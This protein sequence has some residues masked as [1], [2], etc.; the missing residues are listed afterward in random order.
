MAKMPKAPKAS[1]TLK[2]LQAYE[3]KLKKFTE[4]Q[5]AKV[6]AE[7]KAKKERER[8]QKSIEEMAKKCKSGDFKKATTRRKRAK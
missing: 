2:Q 4:D 6:E 7:S 8:L 1:A 3:V 5:C